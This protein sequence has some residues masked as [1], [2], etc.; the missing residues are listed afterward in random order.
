MSVH[1]F[2]HYIESQDAIKNEEISKYRKEWMSHALDHIPDNLLQ[3]F[4]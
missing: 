2:T 1:R 3:E 4:A